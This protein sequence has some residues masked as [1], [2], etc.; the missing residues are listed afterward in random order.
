[1]VFE[2]DGMQAEFSVGQKLCRGVAVDSCPIS[3]CDCTGFSVVCVLPTPN[4]E[5]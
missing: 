1:M 4:G 2:E 5:V 3:F